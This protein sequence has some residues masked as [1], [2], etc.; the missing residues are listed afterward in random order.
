MHCNCT[1]SASAQSS[2]PA[3]AV[4]QVE[5]IVR[6]YYNPDPDADAA[7]KAKKVVLPEDVRLL[8]ECADAALRSLKAEPYTAQ[9]VR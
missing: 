4:Q 6:L 8:D 3:R 2:R 1:V 7:D 9:Q 5:S